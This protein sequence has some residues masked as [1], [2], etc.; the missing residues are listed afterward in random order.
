MKIADISSIQ[1]LEDRISAVVNS[2]GPDEV[3]T[4]AELL[5]KLNIL[6]VNGDTAKVF[7]KMNRR[8]VLIGSNRRWVY[9]TA[10]GLQNL[11]VQINR[12]S[13]ENR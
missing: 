6:T 9:G 1:S 8:R 7:A 5:E 11:E 2:L 13:I 12:G 10:E 3:L 4:S